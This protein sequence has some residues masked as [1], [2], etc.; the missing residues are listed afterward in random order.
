MKDNSAPF[1]N[2][3]RRALAE[4][5]REDLALTFIQHSENVTFK[6]EHPSSEAFL[7]RIH[8]PV[9]TAMGTYGAD[10]D[11]VNS[12]L[13]WLEALCQDTDLVLQ[14]PVRNREGRLVTQVPVEDG[15]TTVNCTMLHWLDGQPYSSDLEP[16]QTVRQIGEILATLHLHASRWEI[17]QGFRRPKRDIAYFEDALQRLRP[18]VA[19]GRVNASD[20]AILETSIALLTDIMRGLNES[21]QTY[22]VIHADAHDG[23]MLY[24][25]GRI[26]LIDFSACAMGNFM[27]DL[28]ICLSSIKEPLHQVFLDGYQSVRVLPDGYQHLIEGF[29]VGSD[30][31]MLSYWVS[32]P[33]A[34]EGLTRYAPKFAREYAAKFNRG[35][36]FWFSL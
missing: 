14:E 21:G 30:V 12:E 13:L 26:R 35:E 29:F 22:G 11:V 25:Q 8:V 7:L 4:Y 18:A 1:N 33:K 24:H 2:I 28:G 34:Q 6:A 16:E 36:F 15:G 17:P 23:N 32:I 31:G 27:Y 20:F 5:N 9:T 19:D 10:Y 3:A